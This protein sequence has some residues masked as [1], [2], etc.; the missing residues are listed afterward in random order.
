MEIN[1][2]ERRILSEVDT[3]ENEVVATIEIIFSIHYKDE[4]IAHFSKFVESVSSNKDTG[5]QMDAKREK[6]INE[7]VND[8]LK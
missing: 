4:I 5:E 7:F 8:Y 3:D 6:D 1:Y 2:K